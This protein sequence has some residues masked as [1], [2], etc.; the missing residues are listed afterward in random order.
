[1]NSTTFYIFLFAHLSSL[2][3]GFGSVMVIDSFGLLWLAKKVPLSLVSKVANVTQRLI[4]VGWCGL[5]ISG[6]GLI[7]MKGYVDNLTQ[8]KIF[9]VAMIGLNGFF[10]H[11]IKKD[12]EKIPDKAAI[13]TI[14]KLRM[15]LATT[16]SQT[17]WW[18]AMLIGFVHR[19]IEHY[20]PWP[21]QPLHYMLLIGG[22]FILA[23]ALGETLL[24]PLSVGSERLVN[25]R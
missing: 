4:W 16:I 9:F 19:H 5:V 20:I 24:K 21:S 8:I 15:G 1:M 23:A 14:L 17:G 3:L 2:I 22:I 13:P 18:G 25:K 7:L 10:L 12:F 11:Y 6:L